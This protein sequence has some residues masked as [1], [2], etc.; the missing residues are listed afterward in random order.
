MD[1]NSRVST[2]IKYLTL[3]TWSHAALYVGDFRNSGLDAGSAPVLIEAD[4]EDGVIA[5]SLEKYAERNT[6]IC[7]PVG[8]DDEECRE[9]CQYLMDRIGLAYDLKNII[10]LARYLLPVP[11]VPTGWR[12]QMLALGSGDPT[13]AICSALIAQAYQSVRYPILPHIERCENALGTPG[14]A[15]REI[16]IFATTASL[17]HVILMYP[18]TFVLSI[19]TLEKALIIA[20]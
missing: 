12:R 8:L 11:P 15:P 7:R 18:L 10:D 1:V 3:S 17:P 13:R 4:L 5:V 6:R 2:A 16:C 20:C 19:P 14:Y 9:V